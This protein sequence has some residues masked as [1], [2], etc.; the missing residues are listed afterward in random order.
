MERA[1][2]F[3]KTEGLHTYLPHY[4]KSRPVRQYDKERHIPASYYMQ[5]F[6]NFQYNIIAYILIFVLNFRLAI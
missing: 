6:Q 3:Q 1:G 5:I 4:T 2:S